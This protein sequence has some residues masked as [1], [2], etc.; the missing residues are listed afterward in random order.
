MA[1]LTGFQ[2]ASK[3]AIVSASARH[4]LTQS[5]SPFQQGVEFR[6][7]EFTYKLAETDGKVAKDARPQPVLVT[8]LGADLFVRAL[9]RPVATTDGPLEHKGTFN[10]YVR[11]TIAKHRDKSDGELLTLIVNE[12]KD[13]DLIVERIPYNAV[14]R[15]GRTYATSLVEIHFKVA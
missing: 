12:C 4:T 3:D 2:T 11:D 5:V 6:I 14:S 8:T 10:L 15:D 13:R 9:I 7:T 1:E